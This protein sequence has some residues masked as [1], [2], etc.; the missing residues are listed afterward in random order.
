MRTARRERGSAT[1]EFALVLP[2]L[3]V[4]ALAL[5]QLGLLVRDRLMVEAAAR[6]GARAAALADDETA[7]RD[8][9]LAAGPGLDAGAVG[10]QVTRT[11]SG[12]SR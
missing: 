7:I 12:V 9:A 6:A 3:L 10:I 8:A 2:L 11:G 4:V 5:L 1:V